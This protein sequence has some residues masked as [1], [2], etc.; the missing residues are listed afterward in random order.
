MLLKTASC[1]LSEV[2]IIIE[3][4]ISS[5][6]PTTKCTWFFRPKFV[7]VHVVSVGVVPY[8]A[9]PIPHRDKGLNYHTEHV[10]SKLLR[11][12]ARRLAAFG[13]YAAC[14]QTLRKNGW[15]PA[16]SWVFKALVSQNWGPNK[17]AV[18]SRH[19][20]FCLHRA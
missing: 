11:F 7:Y 6:R 18:V 4:N 13:I 3:L 12:T 2:A 17:H 5:N 14:K 9:R 1:L 19:M 10:A 16:S 8:R 15:R 20:C